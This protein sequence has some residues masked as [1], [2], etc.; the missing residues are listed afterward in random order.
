M[1]RRMLSLLAAIV[2][3]AVSSVASTPYAAAPV[4]SERTAATAPAGE[5]GD[6]TWG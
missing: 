6:C 4:P 5:C 3:A 1:K 2:L